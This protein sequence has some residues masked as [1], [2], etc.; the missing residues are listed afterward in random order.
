MSFASKEVSWCYYKD[1]LRGFTILGLIAL[2]CAPAEAC[3]VPVFRYALERW[4]ADQFSGVL[5]TSGKLTDARDEIYTSM[6]R[7]AD[8]PAAGLKLDAVRVDVAGV[9][10][11]A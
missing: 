2:L 7:A 3:S 4:P 9:V 11:R 1:V 10:G 5:F 8:A 6:V